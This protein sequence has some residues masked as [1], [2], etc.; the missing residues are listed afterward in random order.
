MINNNYCLYKVLLDDKIIW[1]YFFIGYERRIK[2]LI[3]KLFL[4]KRLK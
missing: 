1:Q 4:K 2:Q 3:K